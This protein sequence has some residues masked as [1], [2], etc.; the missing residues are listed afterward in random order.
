MAKASDSSSIFSRLCF[1]VCLQSSD[2]GWLVP[3]REGGHHWGFV[4]HGIPLLQRYLLLL[5]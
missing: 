3:S 2:L 4:G 5:E 1:Q